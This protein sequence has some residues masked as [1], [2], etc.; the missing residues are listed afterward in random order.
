MVIVYYSSNSF[1][2]LTNKQLVSHMGFNFPITL[3]CMHMTTIVLFS[4]LIIDVLQAFEKQAVASEKQ[5]RSIRW[6]AIQFA[7]S[8]VHGD[9]GRH[10]TI[11]CVHSGLCVLWYTL[12]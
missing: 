1:V 10:Y 6:L 4:S 2:I 5:R 9:G 12:Q 11:L 7:V 3:T 8:L